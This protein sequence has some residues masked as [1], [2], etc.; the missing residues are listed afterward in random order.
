MDYDL[1]VV[2]SGSVGAAAGFYATRA[3]LKVLMIDSAM[4]PHKEGSHH[5]ET[6]IIRHAYGE[7]ARY[8]P[9]VLRAQALWNELAMLTGE[10][11]FRSCGVINIGPQGS[12]FIANVKASAVEFNLNTQSL[13]AEQIRHKWP[14]LNVP[15]GYSGVFEPDSGYLYCEKAIEGY[16]K[17]ARD[18]GCAQLFNCP[19][20]SICYEGDMAIVSTLDGEYRARKLALTAGTWVKKLLPDLPMTPMRKVFAWHQADG[21]YS[22]ENNFPAFTVETEAGDQFYGFPAV[23]DSLKLG[24]H[25]GGQPIDSPKQRTPFGA[26]AEDGPEVFGFLRQF[27]PGVGVC[28][29]GASCT[30]DVTVD[31]DFIIDNVPGHDNTLVIS[32]LSGHGFKFASALGET[33]SLF[34]Q[35][36]APKADLTPFSLSRFK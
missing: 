29:Y 27:L 31:E 26:V 5:G 8:V 30:Y 11:I 13:S 3:G 10:E 12:E 22:E 18:A 36:L 32:G 7:G 14:Q 16:I 24:K 4:P 20:D 33:V 6:R 2:G 25:N 9:L 23:K 19:V 21:R 34:A 1:I 35:G 28:L 15:E 17:L